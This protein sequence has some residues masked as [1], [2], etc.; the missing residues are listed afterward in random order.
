[1]IEYLHDAIRA[2]AGQEIAVAAEIT[3]DNGD[4]IFEGCHIM[5]YAPDR[6]TLVATFDGTYNAEKNEWTFII[7]GEATEGLHGRYWYCICY[8]NANLCFK[9][10]VYLV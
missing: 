3:D 10:P 7:P 8:F 5:L 9:Q 1:M 4:S 2:T 6:E